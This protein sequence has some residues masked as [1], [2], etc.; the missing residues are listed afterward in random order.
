MASRKTLLLVVA[1]VIGLGTVAL[2]RSAMQ[3]VEAPAPAA[4]VIPSVEVAAASRDV[5]VGTI[6][7]ESDIKWIPWLADADTS[8]LFVKGKT[9][10]AQITGAV[11]RETLHASEPIITSKIAQPHEQGFLAA[12][13]TPGMRAMSINLTPSAEVAGFIFPGDHVDVILTHTFSRKDLSNLS[14]RRVSETILRDARVLALDQRIDNPNAEAKVAQIATLE[15]SPKDAEKLAL[16]SDMV[17]TSQSA[18]SKAS[19]TLVLHSLAS[20]SE[21][22]D[23]V[24]N[25]SPTWDSDVSGAYPK[26]SGEDSL[27]QRVQIMRGKVTTENIFERHR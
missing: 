24:K 12:V 13:L 27:T 21:N 25:T 18:I 26:V 2:V 14:E 9:D 17:G 7:K 10:M 4:P 15:V 1:A 22:K 6:L 5:S 3:P 16:A 11:A 23:T 19:M 20:D 8:R